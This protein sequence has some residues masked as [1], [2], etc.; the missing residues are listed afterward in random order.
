MFHVTMMLT[1]ARH[2]RMMPVL[3]VAPDELVFENR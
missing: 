1:Y 2:A 3:G